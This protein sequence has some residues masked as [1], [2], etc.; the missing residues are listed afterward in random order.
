MKPALGIDGLG[1]GGCIVVIA[2]EDRRPAHQDLAVL[3]NAIL[4]HVDGG[5]HGAEAKAVPAVDE[6]GGHGLGQTVPFEY[7]EPDAMEEFRNLGRQRRAARDQEATAV[8]TQTSAQL[9]QDQP[10]GQGVLDAHAEEC[11]N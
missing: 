8:E 1:R 5:S 3:G 4:N 9:G 7:Q 6:R 10:V 2:G 11:R